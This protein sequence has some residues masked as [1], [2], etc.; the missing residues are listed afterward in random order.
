MSMTIDQ[1]DADD[2]IEVPWVEEGE[3]RNQD[4]RMG[5]ETGLPAAGLYARM[6][7]QVPAIGCVT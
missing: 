5:R 4:V 6:R 1:L 2:T 3:R 7:A